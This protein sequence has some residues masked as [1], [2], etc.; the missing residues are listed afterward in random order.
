MAQGAED[1]AVEVEERQYL[2][3]I[4]HGERLD[5]VDYKWL[6]T[7]ERPYDPPLTKRGEKQA[8]EAANRFKGKVSVFLLN[9]P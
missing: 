7:A 3:V 1:S 9:H 5:N 4:R 6:D 8:C 2:F